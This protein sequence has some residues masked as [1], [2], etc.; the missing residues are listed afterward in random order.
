MTLVG[1]LF[2][3]RRRE[4]YV[5]VGLQAERTTMAWQRTALGLGGVSA[6]LVHLSAGNVVAAVP[7]LAGLLV[8]VGLLVLAERRYVRMVARLDAE[9]S[10]LGRGA[11]RLVTLVVVALS[12]SAIA[13]LLVV[14]T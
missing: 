3:R 1:R 7:G 13:L 9:E 6:L 8:A 11:V 4:P 10:P 12:A 2:H 14:G 5:D